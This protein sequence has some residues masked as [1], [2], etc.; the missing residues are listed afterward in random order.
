M[1]Q[2][3]SKILVHTVFST[4]DRRPFLNDRELRTELHAY[5][6]GILARVDPADFAPGGVPTTTTTSTPDPTATSV[7]DGGAA[8]ESEAEPTPPE[9]PGP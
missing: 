5:V 3:L 6:G 4:K 8:D 9:D 2:S 1:A 7:I